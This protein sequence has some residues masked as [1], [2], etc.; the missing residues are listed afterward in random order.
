M[1]V[2]RIPLAHNIGSRDGT[3]NKDSKLG[4]AIIEVEKKESIA[5]V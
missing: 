3:L 5:A 4:N 2:S 1:P